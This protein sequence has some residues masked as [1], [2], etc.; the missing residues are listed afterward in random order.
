M[1]TEGK[2]RESE[3]EERDAEG[4]WLADW[5]LLRQVRAM[6]ESTRGSLR[7]RRRPKEW[8]RVVTRVRE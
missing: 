3:G 6:K 5:L 8:K 1:G 4:G 7:G 2:E